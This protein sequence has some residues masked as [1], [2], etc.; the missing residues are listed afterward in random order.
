[1]SDSSKFSKSGYQNISVKIISHSAFQNTFILHYPYPNWCYCHAIM[2]ID[3]QVRE[4]HHRPYLSSSTQN[5]NLF[6]PTNVWQT[7]SSSICFA[8]VCFPNTPSLLCNLCRLCI[9]CLKTLLPRP[10]APIRCTTDCQP[11]S[12]WKPILYCT[13]LQHCTLPITPIQSSIIIPSFIPS[14]YV[15][16][17]LQL[18]RC[19]HFARKPNP[20]QIPHHNNN[21]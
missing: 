5:I 9:K 15:V 18:L 20:N 14:V 11:A 17:V 4:R 1:M 3:L 2:S 21:R 19:P 6:S 16:T 12:R 8:A 13:S 7:L 10:V